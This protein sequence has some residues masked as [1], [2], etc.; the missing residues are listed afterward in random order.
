MQNTHL[1]SDYDTTI[2]LLNVYLT[3]WIQRDQVIWSQIFKFYYAILVVTLLPNMPGL[4]ELPPNCIII[5]RIIG[6]VLSVVF[7]YVSFGYAVRL[8]IVS[9]SYRRILNKLPEEFR[10][11]N[12]NDITFRGKNIAR[13]FKARL[14]YIIC[15]ILF[16]SLFML[17]LFFLLF[18]LN[19]INF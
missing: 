14:A 4:F 18:D 13:I 5:C 9:V 12:F 1:S 16:V 15:V 11:I 8:H 6:L 19:L 2:S 17:A 3:E 10:Q 7:F